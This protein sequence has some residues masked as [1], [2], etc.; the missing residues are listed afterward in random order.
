MK[1]SIF[2]ILILV[3]LFIST[4]EKKKTKKT[5]KA[6]TESDP[7]DRRPSKIKPELYCDSCLAMVKE[8]V[9]ELRGKKKESDVVDVV[10]TICDPE[11]YKSYRNISLSYLLDHPPPEMREGCEAF[12][13]GWE[14]EL[15]KVLTNRKNDSVPEQILC[16]EL[17]KACL[18]V[19]PSNV[20]QFDNEI[21][22]DG[23]PVKIVF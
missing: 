3:I 10:D 9:R 15:V 1:I 20:P 5:K 8:S 16:F 19:D 2:S 6:A 23:Q 17:S 11:K 22:V 7:L 14:E 12:L 21:M 4:I 13:S 18:N